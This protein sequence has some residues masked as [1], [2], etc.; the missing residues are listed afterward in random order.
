MT[1]PHLR[2]VENPH[3]RIGVRRKDEAWLEERWADRATR[4]LVVAGTRVQPRDGRLD[5]VAPDEAPDGVRVLLGERDGQAWFAVVTDAGLAK[6]GGDWFGVRDLLAPLA[7]GTLGDGALLLHAIGL[8]EWLFVTRFCPR[9]GG[10]LEPRAAG[11]ELR[12]T[13]CGRTQFPRTDPAVIMI[14]AAGEPG[15]EDERCLLGR[16]AVWPAGRFSTLAGFCEPGE[17]LEDA[18]RREVAEETGVLVGDVEYFGN[19][20]W[21]LPASLMLG[22]IG[23]ATSTEIEVDQDEIEE[24]RWFT[25]A[26][27][28]AEAESGRVVLPRGVSISRSLVEH[29]YGGP[30]PGQW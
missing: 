11:H 10:G 2:I 30:L 20:P 16:Q 7:D 18:V 25:R 4:V 13:Q 12:C 22:F 28:R 19:Q 24:A 9:C 8:A 14:V 6:E 15:A 17:T 29:W 3:D 27:L 26:E 5:W 23:R 1:Q 21:P